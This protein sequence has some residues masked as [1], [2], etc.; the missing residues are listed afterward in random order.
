MW[1][2]CGRD[3]V[4][5]RTTQFVIDNIALDSHLKKVGWL[6]ESVYEWRMGKTQVKWH[7]NHIRGWKTHVR[8][9]LLR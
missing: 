6:E 5:L 8:L 7:N 1:K 9:F 4:W 3:I 2:I